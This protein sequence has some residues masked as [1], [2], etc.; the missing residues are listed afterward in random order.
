[1]GKKGSGHLKVRETHKA[2]W[3]AG[4]QKYPHHKKEMKNSRKTFADTICS[5][6]N[7]S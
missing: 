7:I 2:T 4:K 5:N 3:Q 1:M 6:D